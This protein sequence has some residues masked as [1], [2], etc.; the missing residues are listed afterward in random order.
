LPK[1]KNIVM[2]KAPS[3]PQAV[4]TSPYASV[5]DLAEKCVAGN[6]LNLSI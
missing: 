4:Y 6:K 5:G 1:A 3:V 2:P